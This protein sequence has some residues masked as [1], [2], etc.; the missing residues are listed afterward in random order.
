M[1]NDGNPLLKGW[2]AVPRYHSGQA[3]LHSVTLLA[4]TEKGNRDNQSVIA[5]GPACNAGE[6]GNLTAILQ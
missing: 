2:I 5:S 6:R 3:L 4:M 1:P